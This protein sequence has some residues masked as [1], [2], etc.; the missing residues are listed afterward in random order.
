MLPGI[1]GKVQY[2]RYRLSY[3]TVQGQYANGL[4]RFTPSYWNASSCFDCIIVLLLIAD[5]LH[6]SNEHNKS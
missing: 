5:Q 6:V 3:N 4:A 2:L 1:N